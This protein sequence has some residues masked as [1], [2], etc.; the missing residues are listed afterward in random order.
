MLEEKDLQAIATLIS[1]SENRTMA[2]ME[3]HLEKKIN[4]IDE[5]HQDILRRLPEAEGQAELKSRVRTLE[6]L[7]NHLQ[8]ELHK[9]SNAK[10]PR[11]YFPGSFF[12]SATYSIISPG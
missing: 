12:V 2:Y 10:E 8:D 9:H 11:N 1:Q 7:V 6:R 4:I 5:G 3:S